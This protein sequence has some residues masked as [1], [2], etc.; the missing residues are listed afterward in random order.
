VEVFV[1]A[2]LDI[3]E[4]R[5]PKGLYKKARAGVIQGK[6]SR[7]KFLY[8]LSNNYKISLASLPPTRA[9]KIPR[10]TLIHTN[11]QLKMP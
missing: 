2:P 4:K 5:D 3:V 6:R 10:Y 9:Q 11:A 7:I 8:R 1:D